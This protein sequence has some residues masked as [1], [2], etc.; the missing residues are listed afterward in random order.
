MKIAEA[1]TTRER[2]V[3]ATVREWLDKQPD[4]EVFTPH[5]VAAEAKVCRQ[6]LGNIRAELAD[7]TLLHGEKRYWGNPR[8]IEALKRAV[9]S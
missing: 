7:Y 6:S 4:D 1:L 2:P 5:T 8:A 9:Q 3:I